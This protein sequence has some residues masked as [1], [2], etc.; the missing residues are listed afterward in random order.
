VLLK[1]VY[2]AE[3]LLS[4]RSTRSFRFDSI[5]S[6]QRDRPE[7]LIRGSLVFWLF[8]CIFLLKIFW[9]FYVLFS[10]FFRVGP[11]VKKNFELMLFVE[12]IALLVAVLCT[13]CVRT[14]EWYYSTKLVAVI[15]FALAFI[16]FVMFFLLAFLQSKRSPPTRSD[17]G[18]QSK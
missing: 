6:A 18:S 9:N 5:L 1:T 14:D 11:L 17:S 10:L 4:H 3:G 16:S 7:D 13:A 8:A 2:P 15:G 12:V